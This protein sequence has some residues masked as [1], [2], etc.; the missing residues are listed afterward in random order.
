MQWG[1]RMNF[2]R[3]PRLPKLGIEGPQ[4]RRPVATKDAACSE[5]G[6]YLCGMTSTDWRSAIES[7]LAKSG[8]DA[9]GT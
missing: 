9:R 5:S 4:A 2:G 7:A 1:L 8:K 3:R 6:P